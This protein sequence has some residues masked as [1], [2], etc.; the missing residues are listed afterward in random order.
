MISRPAPI[1]PVADQFEPPK[2][3]GGVKGRVYECCDDEQTKTK[4]GICLSGR[5]GGF[6]EFHKLSSQDIDF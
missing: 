6:G 3:S 5:I 2:T 1:R 4:L